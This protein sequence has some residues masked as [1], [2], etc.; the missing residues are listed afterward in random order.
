MTKEA[1]GNQYDDKGS[2]SI[3]SPEAI[4][5]LVMRIFSDNGNI[6]HDLHTIEF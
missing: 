2:C 6:L 1:A 3:S 4:D 5:R